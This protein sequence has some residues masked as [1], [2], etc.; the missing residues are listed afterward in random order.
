MGLNDA[1]D[2]IKKFEL[3]AENKATIMTAKDKIIDNGKKKSAQNVGTLE[4]LEM[5]KTDNNGKVAK[6]LGKSGKPGKCEIKK[7]VQGFGRGLTVDK[8]LGATNRA[9]HEEL[10][11]L[12]K[13]K[14]IEEAELFP[15]KE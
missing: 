1:E 14:G 15:A 3:D 4:N 10:H 5:T 8:I 9:E 7:Q 11:F 13:W 12:I 2:K 6:H